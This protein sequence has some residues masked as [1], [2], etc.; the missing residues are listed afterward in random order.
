MLEPQLFHNCLLEFLGTLILIL[1]GDGVCAACSL[2]KSKA[3][4]GGWIVVAMGWGLAVMCGVFV[5]HDSGAHLNPAVSVG[6]AISGW[7]PWSHVLPYVL[8][9]MIGAFSGAILVYMMYKDHYDATLDGDT[10]LGTFCTMPAIQGHKMRNLFA[11]F[12][13][14][15]VLVLLI[16][17]IADKNYHNPMNT[18]GVGAFPVT[19]IIVSIGMSLGGVTGYAINPARDLAPRVVHA[20]LPIKDKCGSGWH[21]SWVP[22]VGPLLGA[23][24]AAV[25][26]FLFGLC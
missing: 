17:C 1:M 26:G 13:G 8:A 15:F 21:Y 12:L 18:G 10:K 25:I 23:S 20:I 11:E 2:N 6:L 22:V 14:T 5:A 7:F 3:Q 9:Q 19:F 16:L 24:C 4:G